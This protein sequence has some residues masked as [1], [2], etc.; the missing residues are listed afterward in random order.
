MLAIPGKE[1]GVGKEERV[2]AS[3]KRQVV[4]GNLQVFKKLSCLR[5]IIHVC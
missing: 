1:V 2:K 4:I 5:T 3:L